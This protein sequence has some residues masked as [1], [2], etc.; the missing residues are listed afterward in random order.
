[1]R[2]SF[3]ITL[4]SC[5]K[6][7]IPERYAARPFV[8]CAISK[9]LGTM[10]KLHFSRPSD[11]CTRRAATCLSSWVAQPFPRRERFWPRCNGATPWEKCQAGDR[12]HR[13]QRDCPGHRRLTHFLGRSITTSV[14]L[15]LCLLFSRQASCCISGSCRV[16]PGLLRDASC[17]CIEFYPA[18][19]G[20]CRNPARE[21]GRALR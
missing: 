13:Q 18:R 17:R 3:I 12:I 10:T 8:G 21:P 5:A 4:R 1:M 14:P 15:V 20:S 6:S 7:A 19:L 9:L 16:Y 2:H 11:N